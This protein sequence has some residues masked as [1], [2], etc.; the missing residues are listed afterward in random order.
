MLVGVA[1][2]EPTTSGSGELESTVLARL[3]RFDG[4]EVHRGV[5]DLIDERPRVTAGATGDRDTA[6][7][8]TAGVDAEALSRRSAARSGRRIRVSTHSYGVLDA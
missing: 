3:V 8:Q 4:S 5:G 7:L 6:D 1:G 2:F